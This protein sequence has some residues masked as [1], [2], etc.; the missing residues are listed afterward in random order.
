M[1]LDV[2]TNDHLEDNAVQSFGS[3]ALLA[4]NQGRSLDWYETEN[5]DR[6]AIYDTMRTIVC[7]THRGS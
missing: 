2:S 1:P 5:N 7:S 6:G 4:A 3:R